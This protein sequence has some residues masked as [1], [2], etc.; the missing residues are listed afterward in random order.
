MNYFVSEKKLNEQLNHSTQ[1]RAFF[2][3]KT[4]KK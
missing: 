4:Y 3:K 1:N 2:W